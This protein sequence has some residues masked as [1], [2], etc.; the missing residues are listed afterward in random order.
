MEKPQKK[1]SNMRS[2]EKEKLH[3]RAPSLLVFVVTLVMIAAY[4]IS[5][6]YFAKTVFPLI[7]DKTSAYVEM[8]KS[9]FIPEDAELISSIL[10]PIFNQDQAQLTSYLL[11]AF[12][13]SGVSF[14][15]FSEGE[16]VYVFERSNLSQPGS[17]EKIFEGMNPVTIENYQGVFTVFG[18]EPWN[19]SELTPSPRLLKTKKSLAKEN[20]S[21]LYGTIAMQPASDRW[22]GGVLENT[23][24]QL[25]VK[26]TNDP[27]RSFSQLHSSPSQD[28][29]LSYASA[30]HTAEEV[31]FFPIVRYLLPGFT[32]VL[33]E[34]LATGDMAVYA[35]SIDDFSKNPFSQEVSWKWRGEISQR[36]AVLQSI[37][38]SL[39]EK[40]PQV[41]ERQ[42][43]D[44][45][46]NWE[47]LKS[48]EPFLH[49]GEEGEITLTYP[50][51]QIRILEE[52]NG[53]VAEKLL[54]EQINLKTVDN[55]CVLPDFQRKGVITSEYIND[56]L[57]KKVFFSYS[58]QEL[59][60]CISR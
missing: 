14:G 27:E 5:S 43:P 45:S 40:Y 35:G 12:E 55:N 49:E 1:Q 54:E 57:W 42:L 51:G 36:E 32:T 23:G 17:A 26:L 16:S 37:L 10:A 8:K 28:A 48:T 33:L 41:R 50:D 53:V 3:F 58:Q 47:L 46:V 24:E 38:Q 22:Y 29:L 13:A 18:E 6:R 11:R 15:V 44:G 56:P 39:A 2:F 30:N 19:P 60:V 59:A 7:T 9:S 31:P 25:T 4:L 21:N 34:T 20:R 52:E